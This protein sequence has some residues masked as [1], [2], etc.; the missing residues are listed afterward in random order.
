MGR[1]VRLALDRVRD[2]RGDVV[3]NGDAERSWAGA[4]L[5]GYG[6]ISMCVIY[7]AFNLVNR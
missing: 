6:W 3:V 2:R 4:V 7:L 5:A 1:C